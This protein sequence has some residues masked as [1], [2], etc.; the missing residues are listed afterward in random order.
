MVGGTYGVHDDS[1]IA[2]G[3]D[4]S[5][6]FVTYKTPSRRGRLQLSSVLSGLL[7]GPGESRKHLLVVKLTVAPDLWAMDFTVYRSVPLFSADN[8]MR[9]IW[10]N[11]HDL[12]DGPRQV[13]GDFLLVLGRS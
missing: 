9:R 5:Y 11:G 6:S 2:G 4:L 10:Q 13:V 8:E 12:C 3:R 1:R 7:T